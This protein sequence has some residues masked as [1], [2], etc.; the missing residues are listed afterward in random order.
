[1]LSIVQ[2]IKVSTHNV[3]VS[4]QNAEI[5]Q[6]IGISKQNAHVILQNVRINTM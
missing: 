4:L 5:L 1:M 6:N 2:N 3:K